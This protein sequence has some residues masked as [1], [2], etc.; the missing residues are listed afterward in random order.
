M[1]R[2]DHFV[3]IDKANRDGLC[4]YFSTAH[5]TTNLDNYWD[6]IIAPMMQT[7]WWQAEMP[8]EEVE[9]KIWMAAMLDAIYYDPMKR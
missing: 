2:P 8:N 3:C 9:Q 4:D 1:K 6:R 5:F 7:P